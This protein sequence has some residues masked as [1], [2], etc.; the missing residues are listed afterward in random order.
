MKLRPLLGTVTAVVAFAAA[1]LLYTAHPVK[2]SD[3]QDTYNLAT[4]GNTSADITDVYVFPAP[5]NANNVVFA[6]N[7]VPLIPPGMGTTKFFDPT[8]LWQFKISH[9]ASGVEDQVIQMTAKG[10]GSAQT[11]SVYG[12]IA[13][14]EV[15]TTNT[16]VTTANDGAVAYN[17][18][19]A[20]SN[21]VTFFAGP[22]SDPFFFDLFA[23]FTFLGDRNYGTHTSQ[24]DPGLET[25]SNPEGLGNGDVASNISGLAP[26]YDKTGNSPGPNAPAMASFNGFASGTMSTSSGGNG[27]ALGAYACSTNPASDT[28]D[29]GPF[30]VLSYVVEVPKSLLTTGFNTS[31]IHV[32]ATVS[33]S[34]GS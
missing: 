27:G 25:S 29:A 4:R 1:A 17:T 16:V 13:P 14:N 30:N 3:H 8:L 24:S 11:L 7:V 33:S 31:K 21:G 19:G 9:Q 28:L 34:T 22:R 12:P 18:A 15:G 20:M 10:T 6:M 26:S 23:F 32:W 2:S 5:D